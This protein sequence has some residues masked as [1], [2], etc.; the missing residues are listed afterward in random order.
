MLVAIFAISIHPMAQAKPTDSLNSYLSSLP[1]N[2][3][4]KENTPQN[5]VFTCDYFN[6]D[7]TGNVTGKY[8]VSA[9]YTRGLPDGK[10]RWD[11]VQIAEAKTLDEPIAAGVP[12]SY[13]NG[14]SYPLAS[15]GDVFKQEFF[16]GFPDEVRTKT[17]VWDTHMLE[18]FARGYLDQLKLN[19]PLR[20][21]FPATQ[22]PDGGVFKNTQ[23]ELTW[24]GISKM[25]GKV[26][27]LIEYEAFFNQ[28]NLV[29]NDKPL[30]AGSHYW[31]LIWLS[32]TDKQLERATL[33]EDVVGLIG[34]TVPGEKQPATLNTFRTGVF[35]RKH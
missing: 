24:I 16:P 28:L 32:L 15:L 21:N 5:Y 3:E 22:F 31:G 9:E 7:S 13:M 2:L 35:E 6:I 10:V 11:N 26:C 23:P 12:Q 29:A 34:P 27:A 17:L 4:L 18:M 25:N 33:R 20:L 8:R 14:F 1:A 19:T 30:R